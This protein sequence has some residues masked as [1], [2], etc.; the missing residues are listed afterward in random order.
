M[1][2]SNAVYCPGRLGHVNITVAHLETSVAFYRDVCGLNLEFTESG[3]HGAFMGTGLTPHDIGMIERGGEA[4]RGRDGEVQIRKGA[5]S[6]VGLNHFAWEVDTE[7]VLVHAYA[8]RRK[9]SS[10]HPEDVYAFDHRIAKSLYLKDPDGNTNEFYAD[11]EKD[12]RALANG[13]V[14]LITSAWVPGAE[15]PATDARWH[16]THDRREVPNA[17]LRPTRLSHVVLGTDN[18]GPML[19]FYQEVAGLVMVYQSEAGALFRARRHPTPYQLAILRTEGRGLH[20]YAFE[21]DDTAAWEGASARLAAS[22]REVK[23]R[24]GPLKDSLYLSDPDGFRVEF[25][26]RR[27]SAFAAALALAD[28]EERLMAV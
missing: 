25:Y 1:S 24:S 11:S 21:I 9:S 14:H 16:E 10:L 8:Y 2:A 3:I 27:Q 4:R 26:H 23:R 12:W 13:D 5:V 17:L 20:H 6:A 28:E 18:L 19:D 22:G 15:P 7:E